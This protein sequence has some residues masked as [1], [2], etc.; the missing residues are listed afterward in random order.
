MELVKSNCITGPAKAWAPPPDAPLS[1]WVVPQELHP[2]K[3]GDHHGADLKGWPVGAL[4]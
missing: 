4:C 3:V 1:H 2:G